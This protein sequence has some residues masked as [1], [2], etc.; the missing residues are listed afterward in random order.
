MGLVSS[1]LTCLLLIL[2]ISLAGGKASVRRGN[3]A[4]KWFSALLIEMPMPY[5]VRPRR[6]RHLVFSATL[7]GSLCEYIYMTLTI[8]LTLS[9]LELK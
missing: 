4:A 2:P 7:S 3:V 5:A 8:L 6:R 9:S 1:C